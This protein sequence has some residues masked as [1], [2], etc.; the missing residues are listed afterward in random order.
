MPISLLLLPPPPLLL[1]I[2][3]GTV[4]NATC[5]SLSTTHGVLML[6]FDY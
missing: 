2:D 3:S 1:P 6:Y 4:K 5:I